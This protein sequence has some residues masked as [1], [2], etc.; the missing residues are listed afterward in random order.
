MFEQQKDDITLSNSFSLRSVP[1]TLLGYVTK[2]R[3]VNTYQTENTLCV[4]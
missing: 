3:L 2:Q 1:R 4:K